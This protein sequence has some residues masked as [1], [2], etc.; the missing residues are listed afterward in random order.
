[1]FT[2]H[3]KTGLNL[4]IAQ[5]GEITVLNLA[6]AQQ[7]EILFLETMKNVTVHIQNRVKID[8]CTLWWKSLQRDYQNVYYSGTFKRL[9]T[10]AQHGEI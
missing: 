10:I 8:N 9:Q 2:I 3:G 7:H 1:M 5:H 6:I 4:I